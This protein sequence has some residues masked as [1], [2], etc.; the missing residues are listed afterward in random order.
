MTDY[1]VKPRYVRKAI[2]H[3]L[4]KLDKKLKR[5]K[6]EE[7]GAI[8]LGF[9]DD[10]QRLCR[11]PLC[12]S[13]LR[14]MK[15]WFILGFQVRCTGCKRVLMIEML[16]SRVKGKPNPVFSD[17]VDRGIEVLEK[18]MGIEPLD[19]EKGGVAKAVTFAE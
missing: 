1:P 4:V 2:T 7:T 8:L 19:L 12:G 11:C 9:I 17:D 15:S 13:G 18:E 14:V 16:E 6:P 3:F 10:I 5:L